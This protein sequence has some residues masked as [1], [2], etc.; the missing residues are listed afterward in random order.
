VQPL[1]S[2]LPF[3]ELAIKHPE[4]S[5]LAAVAESLGPTTTKLRLKLCM[6]ENSLGNLSTVAGWL[7]LLDALPRVKTV[8]ITFYSEY[9]L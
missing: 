5:P 4:L 7:E 2:Q 6:L 1:L 8:Q 9:I 3:I